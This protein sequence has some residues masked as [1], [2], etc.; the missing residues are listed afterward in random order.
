[1]K[2][3]PN[4]EIPDQQ[5]DL[6]IDDGLF[7]YGGE[8]IVCRN[9]NPN[10]LYKLFLTPVSIIPDTMTDNKLKKIVWI[11][12]HPLEHTV[13]PTAA[14]TNNGEIIGYEMTYDRDDESLLNAIL[15]P[16]ETI[17]CLQE[18]ARILQY[19]ASKDITYGDVKSDNI[20]VN[21]N[22]QIKFCDID[23]IRIGDMPVDIMSYALT[24]YFKIN[25]TIDEKA[26]AYMHNLLALEQLKY[27]GTSYKSI[28]SKIKSKP[29]MPEF[30]NEM[31]KIFLSLAK[32]EQFNGEYAIQYIKK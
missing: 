7:D 28:L 2:R 8:A 30:S 10:T 20:L 9:N 18:T 6:I 21:N 25:K 22:N 16:D 3:L 27:N 5:L 17:A 29:K 19:Y 26:D 14:I 1:M 15:T 32:P 12:N 31:K 13:M 23:N 24:D 4:I 11:Y